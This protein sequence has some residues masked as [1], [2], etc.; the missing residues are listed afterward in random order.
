[1][2]LTVGEVLLSDR[3]GRFRVIDG[4]GIAFDPAV[5]G[6]GSVFREHISKPCFRKPVL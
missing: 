2:D 6:F 3:P 4:T 5:P 1:M